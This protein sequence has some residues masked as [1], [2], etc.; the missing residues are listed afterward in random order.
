MGAG[1]VI[2]KEDEPTRGQG[3]CGGQEEISTKL[4]GICEGAGG[5]GG[6]LTDLCGGA[7]VE[8]THIL[9]LPRVR[10]RKKNWL[11]GLAGAQRRDQQSQKCGKTPT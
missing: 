8:P 11:C 9:R 4:N 10:R 2:R 6:E 7:W 5:K 3:L 1:A